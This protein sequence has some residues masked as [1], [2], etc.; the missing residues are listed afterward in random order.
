MNDT[1]LDV[2]ALGC[3]VFVLFAESVSVNSLNP[4]Y[5]ELASHYYSPAQGNFQLRC[6]FEKVFF[7]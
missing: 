3:I 2:Q 5:P 1:P 4:I 6:F 7:L